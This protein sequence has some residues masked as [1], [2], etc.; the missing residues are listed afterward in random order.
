MSLDSDTLPWKA[1]TPSSVDRFVTIIYLFNC[2]LIFGFFSSSPLI[3][4]PERNMQHIVSGTGE[5][6]LIALCF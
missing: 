5:F 1:P 2:V 6:L 3:G 4:E